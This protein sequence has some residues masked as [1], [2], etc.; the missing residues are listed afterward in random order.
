LFWKFCFALA[1]ALE[2]LSVAESIAVV[3]SLGD[4]NEFTTTTSAVK[5]VNTGIDWAKVAKAALTTADCI[6]CAMSITACISCA[7]GL[8]SLRRIGGQISKSEREFVDSF[9]LLEAKPELEEFQT[10]LGSGDC[11]TCSQGQADCDTCIQMARPVFEER[12]QP[13]LK[14][15]MEIRS[16]DDWCS[17]SC[18]KFYCWMLSSRCRQSSSTSELPPKEMRISL[19]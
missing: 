14:E 3:G 16:I 6:C 1:I 15:V 2:F 10:I 17:K 4:E 8:M 11:K 13:K 9:L 7:M 19:F 18:S 12:L 5:I